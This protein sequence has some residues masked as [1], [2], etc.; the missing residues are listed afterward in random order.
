[1]QSHQELSDK[2]VESCNRLNDKI[3]QSN[4]ELR[5]DF[6]RKMEQLKAE[7]VSIILHHSHAGPNE[8]PV[9]TLPPMASTLSPTAPEPELASADD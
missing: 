7:L 4:R 2:I 6:T 3:D 5:E 9:F 8:P 1:M